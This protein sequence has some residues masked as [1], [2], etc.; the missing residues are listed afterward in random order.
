MCICFGPFVFGI[1]S[2]RSWIC[3]GGSDY[4]E[5]DVSWCRSLDCFFDVGFRAQDVYAVGIVGFR[6]FAVVNWDLASGLRGLDRFIGC[7]R[8]WYITGFGRGALDSFCLLS[9]LR[10]WFFWGVVLDVDLGVWSVHF[11]LVSTYEPKIQH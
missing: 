4:P 6:P 3:E 1:K 8:F 7:T 11:V 9:E 2:L 5:V 10:R